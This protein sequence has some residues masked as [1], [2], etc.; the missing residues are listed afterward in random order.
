MMFALV[1]LVFMMIL[2]ARSGHRMIRRHVGMRVN[3]PVGPRSYPRPAINQNGVIRPS[4]ADAS[5]A[6]GATAVPIVMPDPN[7]IALPT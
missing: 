6:H 7:R 1:G 5:P 4:E 2:A 3:A